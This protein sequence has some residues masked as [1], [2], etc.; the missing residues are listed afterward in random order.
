MG[1]A[2]T[3]GSTIL[4]RESVP[5]IPYASFSSQSSSVYSSNKT[6]ET[7]VKLKTPLYSH[8]V[9][10]SFYVSRYLCI[11]SSRDAGILNMRYV[12]RPICAS[13][14]FPNGNLRLVLRTSSSFPIARV[15]F[16]APAS[17][18]ST[19]RTVIVIVGRR[20]AG[21][22]IGEPTLPSRFFHR[23]SM[24]WH[25]QRIFIAFIHDGLLISR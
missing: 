6:A 21:I 18:S 11:H 12:Q 7:L 22:S 15:C 23:T 16:L 20:R 1:L 10:G 25:G 8:I 4:P 5:E 14:K 24:T 3:I 9:Y 13:F 17:P 2:A 19:Q